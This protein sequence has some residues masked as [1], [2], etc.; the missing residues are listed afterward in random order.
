[1]GSPEHGRQAY[2]AL[3]RDGSES[4]AILT[5]HLS[6]ARNILVAYSFL[7]ELERHGVRLVATDS[8]KWYSVAIHWAR[9]RHRVMSGG[10][11]SC[12]ESFIVRLRG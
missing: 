6:K 5:L 11:H 3:G 1:M 9:L 10:V 7:G 8:A 4:R 2:M 12:V